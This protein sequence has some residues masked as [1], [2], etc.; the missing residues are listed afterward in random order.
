MLK[1]TNDGL[2]RSGTG[3]F[4][5]VPIR[6]QWSVKG[7]KVTIKGADTTEAVN[8]I[9]ISG[10]SVLLVIISST[11]SFHQ[12]LHRLQNN[13]LMQLKTIVPQVAESTYIGYNNNKIIAR[14]KKM[15]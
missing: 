15:S 3:C 10:Q 2:T 14:N 8:K 7:L 4:I 6:Q 12:Y 13:L 5:T 11:F 1:I 9:R